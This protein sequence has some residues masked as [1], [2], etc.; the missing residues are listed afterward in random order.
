MDS[1]MKAC[2]FED[3]G[4]LKNATLDPHQNSRKSKNI[5]LK[6]CYYLVNEVLLNGHFKW[7]LKV[8]FLMFSQRFH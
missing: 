3:V 1:T 6:N 5:L 2:G 8:P 4:V 7:N